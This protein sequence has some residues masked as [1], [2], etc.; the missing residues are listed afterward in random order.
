[1]KPFNSMSLISAAMLLV[2]LTMFPSCD[3]EDD[4]TIENKQVTGMMNYITTGIVPLTFDSTGQ[5]PLTARISQSGTGTLSDLGEVTMVSVFDFD[6]TT[7]TGTDFVTTYTGSNA[8]DTFMA[9]GTSQAQQDGTIHVDE[10]IISGTGKFAK[11]SGGGLT[12]V[13]LNAQQTAGTGDVDW[14]VTY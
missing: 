1:M 11:I 12:I 14:I 7:G 3:Q 2:A 8:A 9:N 13:L 6:F 5:V 10:N 4:F